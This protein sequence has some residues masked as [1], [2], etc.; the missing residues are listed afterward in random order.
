MVINFRQHIVDIELNKTRKF[1][2]NKSSL[3]E[4]CS[5]NSC[6]NFEKAITK[7]S[8]E[9]KAFFEKL[10]VDIAK[11]I[12]MYANYSE[13]NQVNYGGFY[14]ICGIIKN[15][16]SPWELISKDSDSTLLHLNTNKMQDINKDFSFGFQN[17]CSVSCENFPGPFFQMEVV[18]NLPWVLE[19]EI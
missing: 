5:C 8:D 14:Y 15:G 12:E 4:G 18:L 9:V 2:A 13:N 17:E 1:Y 6:K 10:G 11:P 19:N 3:S 16:A 7:I